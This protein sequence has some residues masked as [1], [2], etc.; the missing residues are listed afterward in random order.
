MTKEKKELALEVIREIR[1]LRR[2][3]ELLRAKVSTIEFVS[4]LLHT[5]PNYPEFGASIDKAWEL[6][7]ELENE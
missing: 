3:N 4:L 1:S 2:E 5:K 6:E 7:R